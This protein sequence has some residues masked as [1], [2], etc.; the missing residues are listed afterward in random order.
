MHNAYE[1]V[2]TYSLE[3][4]TAC[5][6]LPYAI[7]NCKI[8]NAQVTKFS[9]RQKQKL[10]RSLLCLETTKSPTLDKIPRDKTS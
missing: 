8:L 7:Q 10:L 5:A 6:L 1:I 9:E 4:F 3:M 2:G